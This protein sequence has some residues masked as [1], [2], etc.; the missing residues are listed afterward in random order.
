VFETELSNK[1]KTI[2]GVK[3]VTYDLPGEAKEQECLFIEL[4][5]SKNVVKDGR[6]KAMVSGNAYMIAPNEKMPFGFFSKAIK[7]ADHALTKDLFFSDIE[8]NAQRYRD[9]VQRGFSFIYFF[10]SQYDPA[11]GTI[12][13]VDITIEE[14]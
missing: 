14:S 2:F 8:G 13:S 1:L 6:V 4:E 9:L 11:V 10:D 5:S 7:Q 3:K 12:T